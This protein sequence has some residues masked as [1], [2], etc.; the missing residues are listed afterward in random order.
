[1]SLYY[2]ANYKYEIHPGPAS[3]FILVSQE[4]L[5][6]QLICQN[7][8]NCQS[9][10]RNQSF[11]SARIQSRISFILPIPS[12]GS[13]HQQPRLSPTNQPAPPRLFSRGRKITYSHVFACQH[14][15]A[16][17]HPS[18]MFMWIR[19][20][21]LPLSQPHPHTQSLSV[22]HNPKS[23]PSVRRTSTTEG[24][25]VENKKFTS[26]RWIK[27][28]THPVTGREANRINTLDFRLRFLF[29]IKGFVS[30]AAGGEE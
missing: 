11:R 27:I 30:T 3:L 29:F 16:G 2:G 14:R 23:E 8:Q 28:D 24:V 25:E 1:M 15:L 9:F 10:N 18:F 19:P 6:Y 22:P 17:S 4:D 13:G 26:D 20:Q 12:M 5:Q 7:N 21:P